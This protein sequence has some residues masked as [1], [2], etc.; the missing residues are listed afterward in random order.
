[1]SS[2]RTFSHKFQR[3]G[4]TKTLWEQIRKGHLNVE[5]LQYI[6]PQTSWTV[7][8]FRHGKG[9]FSKGQHGLPQRYPLIPNLLPHV[10]VIRDLTE[11]KADLPF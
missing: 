7:F 10:T 6:L 5:P 2:F 8:Y 9:Y 1:M 4:F 11:E 3:D